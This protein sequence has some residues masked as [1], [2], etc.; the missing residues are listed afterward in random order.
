MKR[1]LTNQGSTNV[2]VGTCDAITG[3]LIPESIRK[4]APGES[5]EISESEFA[6]AESGLADMTVFE[7]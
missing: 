7:S 5:Y 1:T 4:V 6:L 3:R 2:Y